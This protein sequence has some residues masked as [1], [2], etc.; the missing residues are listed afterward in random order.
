MNLKRCGSRRD[1]IR[2][3]LLVLLAL[4][5]PAG[6]PTRQASAGQSGEKSVQRMIELMEAE[7][8]N[9]WKS[10]KPI[11]EEADKWKNALAAFGRDAIGPVVGYY[12]AHHESDD[13]DKRWVAWTVIDALDRIN[14]K[15]ALLELLK[16]AGGQDQKVS[17]HAIRGIAGNCTTDDLDRIAQL[18]SSLPAEWSV[19]RTALVEILGRF[20][21]Q[22]VQDMLG[23]YLRDK[24]SA[25][26]EGALRA[27]ANSG[28]ATF[29]PAV[30]RIMHHDSDVYV[31]GAAAETA[32]TLGDEAGVQYL[33]GQLASDCSAR[34]VY[35]AAEA[36][37]RLKEPRA[38][39]R[40]SELLTNKDENI[41]LFAQRA[42]WAIG[43][44]EALGALK[45][46]GMDQWQPVKD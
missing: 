42:L 35:V 27:V 10:Q 17:F 44:S 20:K 12:Q 29:L 41:S 36:L 43:T 22:A 23:L 5:V 25:I 2:N 24:D 19:N 15:G 26:R 16:L 14:D 40:L 9:W 11:W 18:V 4:V 28:D 6:L 33:L 46:A 13:P 45:A 3:G 7:S 21:G 37:G 34:E 31:R 1:G 38:V 30:K 8:R 32:A 39:S